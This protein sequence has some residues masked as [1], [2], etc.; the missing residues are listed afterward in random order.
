[1]RSRQHGRGI[2]VALAIVVFAALLGATSLWGGSAA[3]AA[4]PGDLLAPSPSPSP[5]VSPSPSPPPT[6][7]VQTI[8]VPYTAWNGAALTATLVLPLGYSAEN[9]TALPC[10]VQPHGRGSRPQ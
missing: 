4:S 3:A 1:M 8:A 9:A 2:L 7:V 6:P 10:I 5:S